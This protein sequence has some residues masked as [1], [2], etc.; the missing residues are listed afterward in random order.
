MRFLRYLLIGLVLIIVGVLTDLLAS[1]VEPIVGSPSVA[2]GIVLIVLTIFFVA[3]VAGLEVWRDAKYDSA[4]EGTEQQF[5]DVES[6]QNEAQKRDKFEGL[7]K[8]VDEH[9]LALESLHRYT[10]IWRDRS[11]KTCESY[12]RNID[13]WLTEIDELGFSYHPPYTQSCPDIGF[14]GKLADSA[15]IFFFF[16]L[17]LMATTFASFLSSELDIASV[18]L[19]GT[20]PVSTS[21]VIVLPTHTSTPTSTPTATRISTITPTPLI[22]GTPTSTFTPSA[23][24]SPIPP[25]TATPQPR[26]N[27][28]FTH[29]P[30]NT[31]NL[32]RAIVELEVPLNSEQIESVATVISEGDEL[33]AVVVLY[34]IKAGTHITGYIHSNR[35][36]GSCRLVSELR[37]DSTVSSD[38]DF[39]FVTSLT[40]EK[41]MSIFSQLFNPN[42]S[43]LCR[44][45]YMFS[46]HL[47]DNLIKYTTFEVK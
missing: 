36:F 43:S 23:T 11:K 24:R 14:L 7:K 9:I 42:P 41:E 28:I 19:E 1:I 30:E 3:I 10:L 17:L 8:A 22:L 16:P 20:I 15:G 35:I 18:L 38:V 6:L 29:N 27:I 21:E 26:V 44:G 37:L 46:V 33:Y 45:E 12:S 2:K 47:D 32:V 39:G 34:N 5:V 13:T 40:L 4:I 25:S 31:K